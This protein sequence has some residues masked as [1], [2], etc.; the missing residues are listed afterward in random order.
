MEGGAASV[1]GRNAAVGF[2]LRASL[3]T[4]HFH[5]CLNSIVGLISRGLIEVVTQV[6]VIIIM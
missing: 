4:A 2:S 5:C 1:A 6:I 3:V